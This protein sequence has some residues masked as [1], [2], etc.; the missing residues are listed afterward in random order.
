[1]QE[2]PSDSPV[3]D[4]GHQGD[5]VTPGKRSN[6]DQP[7]L[8]TLQGALTELPDATY[9]DFVAM[10]AIWE[11]WLPPSPGKGFSSDRPD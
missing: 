4:P 2:P 6:E 8:A 7:S 1:M 5:G 9:E 11:P 10:K 3:G